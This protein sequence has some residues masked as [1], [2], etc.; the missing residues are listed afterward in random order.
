MHR[1]L[2]SIDLKRQLLI[3]LHHLFQISLTLASLLELKL[4]S[5]N[6]LLSLLD[7]LGKVGAEIL[8]ASHIHRLAT[9]HGLHLGLEFLDHTILIGQLKCE[10]ADLRRGVDKSVYTRRLLVLI[11]HVLQVIHALDQGLNTTGRPR[12]RVLLRPLAVLLQVALQRHVQPLQ[13]RI[14]HL[15]LVPLG[16]ERLSLLVKLQDLLRKEVSSLLLLIVALLFEVL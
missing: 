9:D 13:V 11:K 15:E 16:E 8:I 6:L 1:V 7:N 5:T 2:R 14:L 3:F 12:A 4:F 10:G